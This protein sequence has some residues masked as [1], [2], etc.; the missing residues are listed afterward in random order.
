MERPQQ[1]TKKLQKNEDVLR[2]YDKALSEYMAW[3]V[4]KEVQES[5]EPQNALCFMSHHVVI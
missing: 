5:S 2:R 3:G 4:A 1:L